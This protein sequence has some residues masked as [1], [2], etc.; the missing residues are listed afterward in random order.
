[1]LSVMKYPEFSHAAGN[2]SSKTIFNTRFIQCFGKRRF[3]T[4]SANHMP[5]GVCKNYFY[6]VGVFI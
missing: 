3:Q 4:R 6:V 5:F 2:E 1:M